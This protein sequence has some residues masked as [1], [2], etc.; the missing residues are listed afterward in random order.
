MYYYKYDNPNVDHRMK[1]VNVKEKVTCI[2]C[3]YEF[4]MIATENGKVYS[5]GKN[6]R[7]E[8]DMPMKTYIKH[9]REV[10]E[11]SGSII[12]NLFFFKVHF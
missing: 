1:Q 8:I 2:A 12:G 6:D 5:W 7:D 3:S 11:L 4:Y 9:P 10:D